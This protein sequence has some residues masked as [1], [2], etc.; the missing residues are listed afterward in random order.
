V[1][2]LLE[3]SGL[4]T[5]YIGAR[6]TRVT[7]AVDD[8]S[9]TLEAGKTLGIVGESG[10][11]KTTLALTLMRLL[12]PAARIAA[13]SIRFE[14]EELLSKSGSG[15]MR[16]ARG[17][18]WPAILQTPWRSLNPLSR[19]EIR[20]RDAARA[21]GDA[22]RA[23]WTK[24]RTF[25]PPWNIAAPERRVREYPHELS[26]GMRLRVV[27]AN[28]ISGEPNLLSAD[29]PTT[30]LDVTIQ[31]Q[32]LKLLGDIQRQHGLALIFI[33]HNLGIVA[34]MCDQVAVMYAGRLVEAGPVR[35][36][37]NQP[38][39]PYT[40]ALIESIP[41]FGD[42][43]ERLTAIEG[44]PPDPSALPPGCVSSPALPVRG[45]PVPRRSPPGKPGGRAAPHTLLGGCPRPRGR[46]QRMTP[47]L[48]ARGLTKHFA[49]GRS[50][51]GRGGGV[52]R[53]VDDIAF[54]IEPGRTLGV[55]GESGCGKT[56]TAKLVLRLEKP[57]AG[58]ILFQDQDV[59]GL[60]GEGLHFY[61]K[62]VQ[63]VFQDPFASLN[64]RMRV[65]AII[66]EP[67]VTHERL[68]GP[69][70][71]ARVAKLLDVV[72]LPARSRDLF[73]HEFSGGQRQ[74]IAIARALAISPR[75]VVLDEPVSA[76]DVSI[77]AQI[78]NL[79]RDLQRGLGL[80]SLHRPRSGR[81]GPHEP[82]HRRMYLGRIVDRRGGA[83]GH[84][85]AASLHPGPRRRA[86]LA[87]RR[88]AG[89]RPL[90]RR[91][92]ESLNPPAG[93]RFHPRCPKVMPTCSQE[94]PKLKV[95]GVRQVA[96]HLY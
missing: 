3:V 48:E 28:A 10:S 14:G 65:D 12:P 52:V 32:Y 24:A 62:S 49:V 70:V 7:R 61:R 69:A 67:L 31:A 8:V 92:A 84:G 22:R 76:L 21:R 51:I 53:A 66:A 91:G 26:D 93:C 17:S 43:A 77:R 87:S 68:D 58:Q 18:A 42:A 46:P 94:E 88:A 78:L 30:S 41:K 13:G 15:E 55:V 81:G 47:L 57:T 9:F 89:R 40:L 73:P 11:G 71:A 1:I 19:W 45:G 2:G 90:V 86:A 34:R 85:P 35:S 38:A 83:G 33:T 27:G 75:L 80:T 64:P 23:A 5:Q 20:S 44:Q 39:H 36:I 56:T 95:S 29:E 16:G 74:R 72:G 96:C 4:S 82:R 54:T 59:A 79:L 37:F 6:G 50:L 63:A 60:E 25:S